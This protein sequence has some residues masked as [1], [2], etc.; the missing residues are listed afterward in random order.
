MRTRV[1]TQTIRFLIKIAQRNL[2]SASNTRRSYL[3]SGLQIKSD[4]ASGDWSEGLLGRILIALKD[5]GRYRQRGQLER[6]RNIPP[7]DRDVYRGNDK[8][9]RRVTTLA[10]FSVSSLLRSI[11]PPHAEIRRH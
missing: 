11:Q 9:E 3:Q 6:Q 1:Y 2:L 5:R 7:P 4:A 8:A 10:R